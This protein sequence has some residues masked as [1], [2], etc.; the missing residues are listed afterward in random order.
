MA[1]NRGSKISLQ[2]KIPPVEELAERFSFISN[3]ILRTNLAIAFQY[4]IFLIA[5]LDELEVEGTTIAS[6]VHKDMI[7]HSG[8]I[9]ESCLHHCVRRYIDSGTLESEDIMPSDWDVKDSKDLYVISETEKVCGV[10]MHKK[11]EHF[12]DNTNFIVVN[13]AAQKAGILDA[14]LFDKAEKA[15]EMR[16]KIHLAGQSG[17]D[18]AYTKAESKKM[19]DLANEIISEVESKLKSLT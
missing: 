3:E 19:F 17:I 6:S 4:I 7:V 2:K 18:G 16:N 13:R 9:I 1:N 14:T 15:R 11:T 5:I 8:T 12:K 10:T